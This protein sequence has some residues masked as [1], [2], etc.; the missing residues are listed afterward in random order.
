MNSKTV[1]RRWARRLLLLVLPLVIA[2]AAGGPAQPFRSNAAQTEDCTATLTLV[3][4][5]VITDTDENPPYA[6]PDRWT[7]HVYA[8]VNGLLGKANPRNSGAPAG[9]SG[10]LVPVG[11]VM[12]DS[13]VIGAKGEPVRVRMVGGT[14][15]SRVKERDPSNGRYGVTPQDVG[16]FSFDEIVVAE[17]APGE[18]TIPIDVAVPARP[19]ASE[20]EHDG[21]VEL[22]FRLNLT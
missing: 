13:A 2:L 22:T 17:C 10:A 7:F 12:L 3:S 4:F 20:G 1:K 15:G 14:N 21:L 5:S 6:K 16:F 8:Y 19:G 11:T 18:W 9:D